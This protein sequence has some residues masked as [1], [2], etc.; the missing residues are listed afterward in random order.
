M[1]HGSDNTQMMRDS[2]EEHIKHG[3]DIGKVKQT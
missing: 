1:R 3:F 2:T